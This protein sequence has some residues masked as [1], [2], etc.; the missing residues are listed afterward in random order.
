MGRGL[1]EPTGPP[2]EDRFVGRAREIAALLSGLPPSLSDWM[3]GPYLVV[4]HGPGGVGKS[5]L[6]GQLV[7]RYGHE[8]RALTGTDPLP[9]HWLSLGGAV[10]T[11]GT[12][13][14]LLAECGAPRVPVM[15]AALDSDRA[16]GREL[17]DQCARYIRGRVVVLDDVRPSAARPLMEA[18]RRCSEVMV[19][20]TSRQRRGWRHADRLHEVR[21]LDSRDAAEL[22]SR[23]SEDS[24]DVPPA[25][26]GLPPL[27]RIAAT[28]T[29]DV[30][31]QQLQEARTPDHLVQLAMN[32]CTPEERLL[33]DDLASMPSRAPFTTW[34]IWPVNR[35]DRITRLKQLE[36][37]QRCRGTDD[38]LSLSAPVRDAVLGRPVS[39]VTP[40]DQGALERAG[41]AARIIQDTA[42]LL[43]GRPRLLSGD[44]PL[45]AL[46]PRELVPHIDEFITLHTEAGRLRAMRLHGLLTDTLA[47]VLAFLGD[48]HRLVALH[49]GAKKSAAVRRA[50][51]A[52]AR[53]L[54]LPDVAWSLID[55][56][57]TPY[58]VHERAAIHHQSGHLDSALAALG[59]EPKTADHHTAWNLLV[60]GAVLCDQ[61]RV[62]EAARHLR[63]S[64]DVHQ[65]F[66]C[67]RG[68]GWALLHLARVSLLRGMK[69]EAEWLLG[70]ADETLASLG[71][72]R[73]QNW[74]ATELI[75]IR[76]LPDAYN[77]AQSLIKAHEAAGDV[78]GMG[79]THFWLGRVQSAEGEFLAAQSEWQKA[80]HCFSRSQDALGH[81]W[82]RHWAALVPSDR[83]RS[84]A[85]AEWLETHQEFVKTGCVHG[86]AWTTLEIAARVPGAA[87]SAAFLSIAQ[88]DFELLGDVAGFFW[89]S[90]VR[91]ARGDTPPPTDA[92]VHLTK[93]LP[94]GLPYRMQLIQDIAR[95]WA[96]QGRG[97]LNEIAPHARDLVITGSARDV[98]EWGSSPNGPRCRV[99]L[100]LLDESLTTGTTARLLLRVA[101]EEGHPWAARNVP[102]LSATALPLTRAS[103]EPASALL[104]PSELESHG[105]EFD[106]TPHCTGTHR[107]RFTIALERTGTVLQQVETELDILDHDRPGTHAAPQ[108]VNHRGR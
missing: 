93:S 108:A 96:I 95:F 2:D 79:W 106:F 50:L 78:R 71:D 82:T 18:L 13:L 99:R 75:R 6:A 97:M 76:S 53:D 49:R 69:E 47:P 3:H 52:L 88:S 56:D 90:A 37:V 61:G 107:I 102:W 42:G 57:T 1:R 105:A 8:R 39:Y 55:G 4:L 63:Y 68:H 89:V 59:P 7:R 22:F 70:K 72:V 45:D 48:A 38:V 43:D 32:R 66:G 62:E 35:R 94:A 20:V 80:G 12:L 19:I 16:F 87:M 33:L 77:T 60:R 65:R 14:R 11:E 30:P 26:R 74:V 58:A 101:P 28:L 81:A 84:D 85:L 24:L 46:I 15:R 92:A 100:T 34:T 104:R 41:A 21:P 31:L 98:T 67:R 36:L 10:D 44:K 83:P 103:V 86:R 40:P 29:H 9:V 5:A 17:R 51:C 64:A 27:L 73:G 25:T 23:F 54:G 91:I